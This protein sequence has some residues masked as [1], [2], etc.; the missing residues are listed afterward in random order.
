MWK[1]ELD[2]QVWFGLCLATSDGAML[3]VENQEKGKVLQIGG[4]NEIFKF[5]VKQFK[6]FSMSK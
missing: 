3:L 5:H 6:L 1:S 2:E 4:Q